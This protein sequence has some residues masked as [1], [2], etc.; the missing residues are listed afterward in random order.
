MVPH[1]MAN[2]LFHARFHTIGDQDDVKD[3]SLA[4][5]VNF[6]QAACGPYTITGALEPFE[7]QAQGGF[8][9]HNQ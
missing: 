2:G 5:L 8:G 6:L 3:L 1:G 7:S 9:C 4:S